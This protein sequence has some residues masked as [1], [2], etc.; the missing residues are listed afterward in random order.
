M[1]FLQCGREFLTIGS[2]SVGSTVIL[3]AELRG[4][5]PG[6][7]QSESVW[8]FQNFVGPGPVQELDFFLGPGPVPGFEIFLFPGPVR[9]GDPGPSLWSGRRKPLWI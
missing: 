3:T 8:D 4:L 7:D 2:F 5:K 9:F 1:H 6:T